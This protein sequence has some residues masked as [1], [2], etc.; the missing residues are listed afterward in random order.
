VLGGFANFASRISHFLSADNSNEFA[1]I[2]AFKNFFQA[3]K[4]AVPL[5]NLVMA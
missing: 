2:E 3:K 4:S 1:G 5:T